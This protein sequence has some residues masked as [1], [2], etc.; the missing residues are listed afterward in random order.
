M[1]KII[2]VVNF[3]EHKL[4]ALRKNVFKDTA[5]PAKKQ[6]LRYG[7]KYVYLITFLATMPFSV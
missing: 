5:T 7:G 6:G 4:V 1:V 2:F 3:L